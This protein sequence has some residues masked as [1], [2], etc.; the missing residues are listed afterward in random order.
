MI[1]IIA[2]DHIRLTKKCLS[3]V[4]RDLSY[5][6]NI[7]RVTSQTQFKSLIKQYHVGL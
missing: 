2:E 5:I 4:A 7:Q 3:K 1:R 6:Y